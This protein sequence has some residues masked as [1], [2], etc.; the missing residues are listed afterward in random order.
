LVLI[1]YI[2]LQGDD[3]INAFGGDDI[4]MGGD[5]DDSCLVVQETINLSL[6]GL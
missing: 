4:L 1:I 5:G 3:E 6:T 2:G